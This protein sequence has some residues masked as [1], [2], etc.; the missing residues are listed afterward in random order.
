MRFVL[1][2]IGLAIAALIGLYVYGGMIEP[3]TRM[4]EEPATGGT[5]AATTD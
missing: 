2:M 3:E 1:V 4:I 5:D